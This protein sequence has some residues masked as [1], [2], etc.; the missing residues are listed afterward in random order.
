MCAWRLLQSHGSVWLSEGDDDEGRDIYI[1]GSDFGRSC[2]MKASR[3]RPLSAFVFFFWTGIL[4]GCE[5]NLPWNQR[6][7]CASSYCTDFWEKERKSLFLSSAWNPGSDSHRR[8][9]LGYSLPII[10]KA[11]WLSSSVFAG[12]SETIMKTFFFKIPLCYW[13]SYLHKQALL[14]LGEECGVPFFS[15]LY[16]FAKGCLNRSNDAFV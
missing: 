6:S 15:S 4:N 10:E 3:H 7:L 13:K 1:F 9:I 14:W 8:N 12:F 11:P 2:Q 16:I 5:V